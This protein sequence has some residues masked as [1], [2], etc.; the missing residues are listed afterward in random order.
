MIF[1]VEGHKLRSGVLAFALALTAGATFLPVEPVH[2]QTRTLPDFTDLVDQVG[3]SV[4]NIRTVEKVTPRAGNGE[5]D[6]EMQEFFR[7]FFGQPLPGA[8]RSGPRPNRPQQ[9]QEEERPRGVGSGFILT[10]DGYVMTN[11]HVVEDASEVLVTLPDKREFKAKI[12]GADKRSDVAVVKIEA[13]G[14]PAVKVGDI[15]KLRVG[16]WVM[17]IGS[18]FGLENTVTAGIVSAKQRDTGEYLP[19]IQTDVAINPG[20]SGGPLINMRGEVV[21]INSQIYSRSGGFMGISFSIPIDEAIRVSDQLRTSGRVSRGRIGVQIDQVTKDVAEAIGLGKAQ[22]ALVRGVEAGSPGEKAGVEPGDVITKFDGKAIE[23]PSDLPRLV[24]N[25]K[26]GTKST[27]T[28]FRRGALR[29]LNVTI[30][31]IEPDKPS[32]RASDRD[33]TPAKPP[34]SAAAKSLGLAVSDLTDVQKKELKLKGGVKVDAA[35]DAAARAGLREG[36]IILA[37]GNSD[38]S[39]AREFESAIGKADKSKALS[40]L[41][42]RGD[43]AQYALIRPAR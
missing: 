23:K 22:G 8:P 1:K 34:A 13:T 17:A 30:A 5:M 38:I 43:W 15:S 35:S 33:E 7:R 37:V 27:L 9:P 19:F 12:V 20:N 16:E 31:E 41:F 4:V 42:R 24:G 25:T 26:P 3:P 28:V 40:V 18:P 39:N 11:A 21:G 6:E 29:D 36:D 2:A 14:L 10:A 32:K